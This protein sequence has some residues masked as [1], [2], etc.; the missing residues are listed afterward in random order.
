MRTSTR[1]R[2]ALRLDR[3]KP[4]GKQIL[5]GAVFMGLWRHRKHARVPSMSMADLNV[6]N[7]TTTTPLRAPGLVL[8]LFASDAQGCPERPAL[9]EAPAPDPGEIYAALWRD[10][11]RAC[12]H[13]SAALTTLQTR[14]GLL[15]MPRTG[16]FARTFADP[17]AARHAEQER[18][19]FAAEIT[20]ELTQ[21]AA[22]RFSGKG[23]APLKIDVA[24]LLA[25]VVH[26]PAW[27]RRREGPLDVDFFDPAAVWAGLCRAFGG[28]VGIERGYR[29]AAVQIRESFRLESDLDVERRRDGVVL[30]LR[31]WVDAS[32]KHSE[33]KK[34]TYQSTEHLLETLPA[35][36]TFAA[37]ADD[38][39]AGALGE[40]LHR[41]A[42]HFGW[43]GTRRLTSRE[44]IVLC[45][46]VYVVT[47]QTRFE[48]VIAPALAEKLHL[49]LALFGAF[50]QDP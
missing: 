26:G 9:V 27:H 48:F 10:Y 38:D 25:D 35:L 39:N 50:A 42:E 1:E 17:D 47:Y 12:E 44:K 29:E 41:L 8:D 33:R 4:P 21:I 16:A 6:S 28:R 13:F 22:E 36:R 34:L 11:W 46:S 30:R 2:F 19:D 31:V 24:E 14:E 49:F 20:R 43:A 15:M 7:T 45:R 5:T 40:G 3:T 23:C 37:W 32:S 18:I